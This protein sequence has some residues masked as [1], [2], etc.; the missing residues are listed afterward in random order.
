MTTF[1]HGKKH[2]KFRTSL[3]QSTN[4]FATDGQAKSN[5]VKTGS[6]S[7]GYFMGSKID[8]GIWFNF[9]KIIISLCM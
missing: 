5:V 3:K 4:R 2:I 9:R 6:R 1:V 7:G 8:D